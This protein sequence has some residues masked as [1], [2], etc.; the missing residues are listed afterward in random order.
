MNL[1]WWLDDPV[2]GAAPHR[3]EYRNAI[4][5]HPEDCKSLKGVWLPRNTG[6]TCLA[7]WFWCVCGLS[8]ANEVTYGWDEE[9][10][11]FIDGYYCDCCNRSR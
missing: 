1:D 11:S 6:V 7:D 4:L 8:F 5:T 2:A 3:E 9:S 10:D